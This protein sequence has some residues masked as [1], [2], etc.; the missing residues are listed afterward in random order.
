[1]NLDFTFDSLGNYEKPLMTLCNP[2]RNQIGILGMSKDL[3]LTPVF[4]GLS[5]LTFTINYITP[6]YDKVE[7]NR[8]IKLENIGWYVI[9]N[10]TTN[11]DGAKCEKEVHCFSYEYVLNRQP[12]DIADGTYQFWNPVS[13]ADTLLGKLIVTIPSWKIGF[14][15]FN[16][17][18]QFRTF[19][20]DDI[21]LY[22]FLMTDLSEAF[23][24]LIEFDTETKTISFYTPEDRLIKTNIMLSLNN[25]IKDIK[26]QTVS[27]DIITALKIIGDDT[28]DCSLVN[29]MGTN[30]AYNFNFFK[31][32]EWMSQS[33]I[34][35]LSKWENKLNSQQPIYANLLSSLKTY[36]SELIVLK[37]GLV[38][39]ENIYTSL[40]IIRTERIVQGVTNLSDIT[41]QIN[42]NLAQQ[43]SKKTQIS[44]KESQINSVQTQLKNINN[45]LQ[46]TNNFTNV[47]LEELECFIN[48][49]TFQNENFGVLESMSPVEEQE[50]AQQLYNQGANKLKELSQPNYTFDSNVLNYPLMKEHEFASFRRQTKLGCILNFEIDKDIWIEPVLL[51]MVI[52]YDDPTAFQMVFSNKL[53]LNDAVWTFAELRNPDSKSSHKVSVSGIKW[54]Q[55]ASKTDEVTEYMNSALSLVNQ[56]LQSTSNL[57][58]VINQH[59]IWN[60]QMLSNGSFSPQQMRITNNVIAFTKDNWQN[61]SMALG[62]IPN[63]YGNGREF[64]L[65]ADFM[66][67]KLMASNQL[68]ITNEN[69][70]IKMD[71]DKAS[72]YNCIIEVLKSNNLARTY[73]NPDEGIKIQTRT[74]TSEA[75][76]DSFYA[77][78]DGSIIANDI[79]VTRASIGG[80]NITDN[81]I[82]S[83]LQ[84]YSSQLG[85]NAPVIDLN[86][87]GSGRISGFSWTPTDSY[88][89]RFIIN[90]NEIRSDNDKLRLLY[91]GSVYMTAGYI[92]GIKINLNSIST[93]GS[94]YKGFT[95]KDDGSGNIGGFLRWDGSTAIFAGEIQWLDG[96]GGVKEGNS[97]GITVIYGEREIQMDCNEVYCLGWLTATKGISLYSD[98]IINFGARHF[99][100]KRIKDGDGNNIYVL[101][102]D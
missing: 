71:G 88:I 51:K 17:W 66:V 34:D 86:S 101:A 84:S 1:M 64:G 99:K 9:D 36:N 85:K 32:L 81:R 67:G 93:S 13:P 11:D 46:F 96:R 49:G 58:T 63:P 56:E 3:T 98:S 52:P 18:T 68:Y 38:D 33:L 65:V 79:V 54:N 4:N 35:A 21:P 74:S 78:Y 28:L 6:H 39:L 42:Q 7:K 62:S 47:Q 12:T 15:S 83:T 89:G 53:R 70:Y 40:E 22:S 100:P 19:E 43:N 8:L 75:W 5:E 16:L 69:G 50:M 94:G 57:E 30:I 97:S 2:Q 90:S 73:I 102:E 60:R 87:D 24:C 82:F 45:S 55:A 61:S 41:N 91:D 76:R 77:N 72:F 10:I 48:T 31:S 80:F 95:F 27:E 23:E 92:G 37:S 20:T 44:N 59:G 26:I 29:P 25:L 14:V